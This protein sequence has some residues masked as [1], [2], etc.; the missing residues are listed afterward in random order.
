MNSRDQATLSLALK[1][2]IGTWIQVKDGCPGEQPQLHELSFS[3]SSK[4][5][6]VYY[7]RNQQ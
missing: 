5:E 4:A 6:R 2:E 3:L 1:R 7:P